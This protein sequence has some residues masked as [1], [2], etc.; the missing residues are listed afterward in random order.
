MKV[1][2]IDDNQSLGELFSLTVQDRFPGLEFKYCTNWESL[3]DVEKTDLIFADVH[4]VGSRIQVPC[5]VLTISG[6]SMS[7]PDILK[8]FSDMAIVKAIKSFKLLKV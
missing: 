2:Y 3:S 5:K 8:P 1:I 4:G 7:S 6:D